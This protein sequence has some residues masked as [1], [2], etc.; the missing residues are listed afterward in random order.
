MPRTVPATTAMPA[1]SGKGPS[2]WA[3]AAVVAPPSAIRVTVRAVTPVRRARAAYR[4]R[5]RVWPAPPRP[6][7]HAAAVGSAPRAIS[8]GTRAMTTAY[9]AKLFRVSAVASSRNG[10]L[11]A[12]G[13]PGTSPGEGGAGA[14][15]Q[16]PRSASAWQ[17]TATT[18]RTAA[19]TA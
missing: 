16:G 17:G 15:G 2:T 13:P 9:I 11:R 12:T 1:S 6:S 14:G 5:P 18:A 7:A 3:K 4:V 19:R 8:R 10:R